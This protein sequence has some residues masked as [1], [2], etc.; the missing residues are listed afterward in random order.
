MHAAVVDHSPS[1]WNSIS[2][3]GSGG[4]T[5][6]LSSDSG[7]GSGWC[8]NHSTVGAVVA[9]SMRSELANALFVGFG[10][11]GLEVGHCPASLGLVFL[12]AVVKT[13]VFSKTTRVRRRV[14]ASVIGSVASTAKHWISWI[15]GHSS[16]IGIAVVLDFFGLN[17]GIY[18]FEMG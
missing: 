8:L 13:P 2:A 15:R 12:V 5:R 16:L 4:G 11:A 17:G 6:G 14:A 18:H 10:E 3:S 9:S 7:V 1:S